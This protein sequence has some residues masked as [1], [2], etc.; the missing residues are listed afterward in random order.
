KKSRVIADYIAGMSD[1]YALTR[2]REIY[3]L[4]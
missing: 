1:R 3:G 4:A 2:Y